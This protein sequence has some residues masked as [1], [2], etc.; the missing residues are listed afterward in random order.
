MNRKTIEKAVLTLSCLLLAVMAGCE[1][2]APT[3]AYFKDYANPATPAITKLN[4]DKVAPPGAN[5]FDRNVCVTSVNA[6]CPNT[7]PVSG[8]RPPQP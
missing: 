8:W 1:Y 4:P 7:A 6:P 5:T 3:P 2:D